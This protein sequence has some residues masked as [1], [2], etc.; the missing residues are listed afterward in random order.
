MGYD[1][2][3]DR[4]DLEYRGP[5]R[6]TIIYEVPDRI[7]EVSD[8]ALWAQSTGGNITIDP[9][10]P[11]LKAW[12]KRLAANGPGASEEHNGIKYKFV[13]R[14]FCHRISIKGTITNYLSM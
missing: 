13:K 7:L 9:T 10:L 3:V 12:L 1:R 4:I 14:K 2:L 8:M 11:S 6:F 5:D